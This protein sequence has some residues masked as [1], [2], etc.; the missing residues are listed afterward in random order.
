MRKKALFLL[1]CS[2]LIAGASMLSPGRL[3]AASVHPMAGWPAS[4]HT[5]AYPYD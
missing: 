3:V 2:F 5:A 1:T 4:P